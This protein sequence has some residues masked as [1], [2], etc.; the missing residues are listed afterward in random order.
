MASQRGPELSQHY[1]GASLRARMSGPTLPTARAIQVDTR[2]AVILDE[3][4]PDVRCSFAG[5]ISSLLI[6][7]QHRLATAGAST[8]PI[9][10]SPCPILPSTCVVRPSYPLLAS[11]RHSADWRLVGQ[12]CLLHS[13]TGAAKV[14]IG[15]SNTG[16]ECR[17]QCL[18]SYLILTA[19]RHTHLWL[20]HFQR[21]AQCEAEWRSYTSRA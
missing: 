9:T 4:S 19:S 16:V 7:V 17:Q 1:T 10:L 8:F 20:S 13:I 18:H 3:E 14:T 5:H 6:T 11:D 21:E 15:S 12:G 2:G